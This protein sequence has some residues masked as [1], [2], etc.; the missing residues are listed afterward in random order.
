MPAMSDEQ[1]VLGDA[2]MLLAK[3]APYAA[4]R[5]KLTT[6]RD[7]VL[8]QSYRA[9]GPNRAARNTRRLRALAD[10]ARALLGT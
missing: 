7:L 5:H 10:R 1:D 4:V 3:L 6:A 8:S 9:V 2:G